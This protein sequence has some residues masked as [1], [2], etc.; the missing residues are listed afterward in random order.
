VLH[1]RLWVIRPG[2]GLGRAP[3]RLGMPRCEGGGA[4]AGH[5]VVPFWVPLGKVA[6]S[7]DTLRQNQGATPET[8]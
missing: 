2:I 8:K 1:V 4:G 7:W 6:D 3:A 5:A